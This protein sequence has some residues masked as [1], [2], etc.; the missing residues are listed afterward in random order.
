[1]IRWAFEKQGL[2]QDAEEPKPNNKEGLPPPVDVYIE[3]G[4]H[5]EYRYQSELLE[6]PGD[7]EPA[8]QRSRHGA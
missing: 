3:D 6:L 2:Y 4:R 1:M 8:P 5:G 7:L